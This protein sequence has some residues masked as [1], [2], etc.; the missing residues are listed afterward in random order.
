[1]QLTP[2]NTKDVHIFASIQADTEADFLPHEKLYLMSWP[3]LELDWKGGLNFSFEVVE[4]D[5]GRL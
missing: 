5:A 2:V 1:M 3:A 4:L